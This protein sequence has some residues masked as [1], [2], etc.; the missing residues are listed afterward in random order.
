MIKTASASIFSVKQSMDKFSLTVSPWKQG[1]NDISK[2]R[3]VHIQQRNVTSQRAWKFNN[4][5]VRSS[6]I[7]KMQNIWLMRGG[8][9][10]Y[11][12]PVKAVRY[13]RD[14]WAWINQAPLSRTA[15][16]SNIHIFE[17][18]FTSPSCSDA[19][20]MQLSTSHKADRPI[21]NVW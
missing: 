20:K 21:L 19:C 4:T 18:T 7:A 3:E 5:A 2:R 6:N 10:R 11:H 8:T 1:L 12:R 15:R 17:H 16:R 13:R 14:H 9:Y